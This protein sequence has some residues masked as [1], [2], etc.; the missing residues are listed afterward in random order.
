MLRH[1]D[2]RA[3]AE[4]V[5]VLAYMRKP[6]HL[7]QQFHHPHHQGGLRLGGGEHDRS[8]L[9]HPACGGVGGELPLGRPLASSPSLVGGGGGEGEESEGGCGGDNSLLPS[10]GFN[11]RNS[12]LTQSQTGQ[13]GGLDGTAGQG[14]A[15]KA[16]NVAAAILT[17]N[18]R[19]RRL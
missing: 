4:V 14:G 9:S 16:S 2:S 10:R 7:L 12:D 3:M 19:R 8:D 18:R 13:G 11:N 1:L 15:W 17:T 6:R 5:R